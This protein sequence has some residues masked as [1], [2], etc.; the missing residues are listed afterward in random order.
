[1][2]FVVVGVKTIDARFE[3]RISWIL[4]IGRKMMEKR[5]KKSISYLIEGLV[6]QY[7]EEKLPASHQLCV[8]MVLIFNLYIVFI[9]YYALS[10]PLKKG[11]YVG[12]TYK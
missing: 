1:M 11:E 12:P 3:E 6:W 10:L 9:I 8:Q 7:K 2:P 5:Q 4:E